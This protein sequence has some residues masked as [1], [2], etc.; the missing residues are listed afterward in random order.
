MSSKITVGQIIRR[1]RAKE[2]SP[3]Y[4]LFGG[5]SFL[6]DFII[7][8][9]TESYL[10]G[11]ECKVQFSMDQ[12]SEENLFGELSSISLFEDKR[13]IIVREIKKL[14]RD[15]GQKELLQYLQSPNSGIILILISG[16]YNLQKSILKKIGENALLLDVRPPFQKEMKQW[17]K[18][19][20]T[21]KKIKISDDAI[22][23]FIET[24]GD[25][26]SHVINEIEKAALML[27]EEED[28]TAENLNK[29]H[30]T[31]KI[32]H[33]WNLQDSIG[34]KDLAK[35][36]EIS[37]SLIENGMYIQ[38]IV[39]GLTSL[40]QQLLWKKM[41]QS[42]PVGYTGINKIIT[43]NLNHY[44]RKY[45]AEEVHNT[46]RELKKIDIL[47]KSTSLSAKDFLQP[48]FVQMCK[49]QYD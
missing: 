7:T 4:A 13:I 18:F 5:D 20:V 8:E 6:E 2:F 31:K 48:L 41:G 35:S 49:G 12:D 34:N 46:I 16:E 24:S 28:I 17:V 11:K 39:A 19:M 32:Y 15:T 29:V 14:K 30:A 37:E 44:D 21:A 22:D 3:V 45:S 10:E 43:R 33:L 27:G 23:Y 26:I 25:S 1:I 47:S 36:I 9:L 42:Q 40:I 38:Q